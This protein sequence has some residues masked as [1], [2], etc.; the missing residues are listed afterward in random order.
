M[1]ENTL[2]CPQCKRTYGRR[3]NPKTVK[4]G[5]S[6]RYCPSCDIALAGYFEFL[7]YQELKKNEAL[8]QML[9][10]PNNACTLT[11]GTVPAINQDSTLDDP[12]S[13]VFEST[14]TIGK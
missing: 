14:P 4:A 13:A 12:L 5:R 8:K 1:A 2:I 9:A 6:E 3:N 11:D 7:Y 10:K